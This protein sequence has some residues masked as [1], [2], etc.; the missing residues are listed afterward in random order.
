M[1]NTITRETAK[2]LNFDFDSL[3]ENMIE[4]SY[5]E[6]RR[7]SNFFTRSIILINED[8]ESLPVE[9]HGH[10]E[11]NDYI[12]DD[13]YGYDRSDIRELTRVM[14]YERLVILEEWKPISE[15]KEKIYEE[16]EKREEEG[17]KIVEY[18]DQYKGT[19]TYTE[20]AKAIEFGFQLCQENQ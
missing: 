4:D 8:D 14:K 10:W 13:N 9:L 18:L 15:A 6:H 5:Q 7:G 16:I 20:V 3:L 12:W 17:R 1:I 19:P 11:T 2:E